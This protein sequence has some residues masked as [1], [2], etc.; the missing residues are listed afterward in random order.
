MAKTNKQFESIQCMAIYIKSN[1][2]N[3]EK[4]FVNG[5]KI[6]GITDENESEF[7]PDLNCDIMERKIHSSSVG[8]QQEFKQNEN[9][10][11][12]RRP[13]P[14]QNVTKTNGLNK[15]SDIL[16]DFETSDGLTAAVDDTL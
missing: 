14:S 15:L 1:Q 12:Y 5:V 10:E 16:A 4:S 2:N 9:M 7:L 11:K 8:S 13:R 6:Y 3:T